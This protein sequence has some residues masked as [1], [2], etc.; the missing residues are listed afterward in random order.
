[1][2]W[3]KLTRL[4]PL[5]RGNCSLDKN[6][7]SETRE[8]QS[9]DT[10]KLQRSVGLL[11]AV[12]MGLGSIVGTG[13]FV[14]IA[15]GVSIAG[16]WTLLAIALASITAICNGL[17]SAQLAA[18]H[19]VSGGT[20]EYGHRWCSARIG[21]IA[22]WMFMFAKSASAAAAALGFSGYL[23]HLFDMNDRSW[24]VPVALLAVGLVTVIT[25]VGIRRS[26]L[27][28]TLIVSVTLAALAFFVIAGLPS[29]WA[30][31]WTRN[32][33]AADSTIDWWSRSSFSIKDILHVTALMFVAYTGYGRIATLGEEIKDPRRNIPRAIIVTLLVSMVLYVSV[34][35]V[36]AFS[37]QQIFSRL[38]DT[39]A[40]HQIANEFGVPGAGQVLAIGAITAMLGVLLNL[41]LGLS[42]VLLAMGRR[43]EMPQQTALISEGSGVPWLA[44]LIVAVIIGGIVLV[45]DI[46]IAW[47]FSAFAVLI[48]YSITNLC[49]LRMKPA[50]RIFPVW[51]AWIGLTSCLFLAFW[52]EPIVWGNG[53]ALIAVGLLWQR[54]AM[55]LKHHPKS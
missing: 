15:I 34:G 31:A 19:P 53:L 6:T 12:M 39:A 44:T 23:L 45:G 28:N 7:F 8:T 21:F 30:A 27:A 11:G 36:V 14:S 37:N 48:Y 18:N 16:P 25:L 47:S 9:I 10:P 2:R 22:G 35:F 20:Y 17:S 13:V 51:P 55:R 42:R 38:S 29:A 5:K 49:V 4:L 54:A 52:V 46:R 1:M 24:I 33:A 26:S 32:V 40:L 50:E 43:A 41:V 3:L